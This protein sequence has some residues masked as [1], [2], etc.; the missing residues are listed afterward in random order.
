[1]KF[2]SQQPFSIRMTY[3]CREHHVG[4]I[5]DHVSKNPRPPS[6]AFFFSAVVARLIGTLIDA[7]LTS[8]TE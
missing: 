5:V 3:I 8:V 4:G 6:E 1:M 7:F 2:L